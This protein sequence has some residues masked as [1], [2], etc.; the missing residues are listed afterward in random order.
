[1]NRSLPGVTRF[2]VRLDSAL[3]LWIAILLFQT[4]VPV[5]RAELKAVER[6]NVLFLL[7]DDFGWADVGYNGTTFYET[8]HIDRLAKSGMIFT[9]AYAAGSVCSPT[10]NS[11]MT[12]KYPARTGHTN[13]GGAMP[14]SEF[15]LAE[16]FKAGGYA[17][18]FA[19]KWHLGNAKGKTLPE[20]QGFD[21]NIGGCHYGQP[22]T[23][24][25]PY[26]TEKMAWKHPFPIPGLE[27]GEAGDYLT[28]QLTDEAVKYLRTRV[29]AREPFFLYLSYHTVHT[30]LEAPAELVK[31][32]EQKAEAM[33]IAANKEVV[34]NRQKSIQNDP[35]YAAMVECL[36]RSVGRLTASLKTLGIDDSTVIVFM[37]DNGGLSTKGSKGGP[38]SNLPLRAG[39]AHTYEGGIREPMLI[40][41]PGVTKPGASCAVPVIST[42]FY[43]TLLEVA[44]LPLRP[45]QHRDG[46]SLVP[47][48]KG[49]LSLGREAVYWHYPHNHSAGGRA[50]SVIRKGDY[51]LIQFHADNRVELYNLAVDIGEAND[52]SN[53]HSQ[54]RDDLLA[55]LK[56]WQSTIHPDIRYGNVKGN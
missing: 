13:I 20:N 23:Y 15:T 50:S 19:G 21:I 31:K 25:Y 2:S 28:D 46:V 34:Q 18:F 52:L 39:K 37:S 12:G 3:G 49:A 53:S 10:R 32:Y 54:V 16:A 4:A 35:V 51:K 9:D 36:D 22:P 1:M 41:W 45:E 6:S 38:T 44:G 55:S 40:R 17:T 8:P 43:P 14:Q 29:G 30:P 47:L 5:A 42:D 56:E 7:V 27:E 48:L 24:F 33:N 26:Y 11:I